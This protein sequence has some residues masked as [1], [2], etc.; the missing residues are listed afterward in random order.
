MKKISLLL[1]LLVFVACGKDSDTADKND[2]VVMS[3]MKKNKKMYE[4]AIAKVKNAES[5]EEL[6]AVDEWVEDKEDVYNEEWDRYQDNNPADFK[7]ARE[8][9]ESGEGKYSD[10]FEEIKLLKK[11]YKGLWKK[12]YD[13][14]D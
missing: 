5:V 13:E 12:R 1:F 7:V 6:D 10:L 4:D 9:I 8:Q 11:K 2:G 14:L 3:Y